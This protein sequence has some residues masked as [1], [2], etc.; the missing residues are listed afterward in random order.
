MY[1]EK[2]SSNIKDF[3]TEVFANPDN[4]QKAKMGIYGHKLSV[5]ANV[6]S[7]DE[8]HTLTPDDWQEIADNIDNIFVAKKN[9]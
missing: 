2:N 6:V 5:P 8:K 9:K 3:V 1:K 4:Y 7:H